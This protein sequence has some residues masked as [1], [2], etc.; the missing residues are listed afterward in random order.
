MRLKAGDGDESG[1]KYLQTLAE[2]LKAEYKNK[3]VQDIFGMVDAII[4][5]SFFVLWK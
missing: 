3:C 1:S 5:V 2:F 4:K